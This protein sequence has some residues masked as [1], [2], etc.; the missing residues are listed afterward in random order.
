MTTDA[1]PKHGMGIQSA[2]FREKLG[3]KLANIFGAG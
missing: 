1:I 2:R 3:K